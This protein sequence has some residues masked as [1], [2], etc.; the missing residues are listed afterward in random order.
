MGYK[1]PS[2]HKVRVT[3]LKKELT[4]TKD[5]T[6]DH[7]TEWKPMDVQLCQINEMIGRKGHW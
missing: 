5:L 1:G 2:F 7:F 3:S 6:K 4:L